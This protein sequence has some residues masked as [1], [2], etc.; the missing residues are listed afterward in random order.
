MQGHAGLLVL[1]LCVGVA[2]CCGSGHRC[3]HV[4]YG[5][6]APLGEQALAPAEPTDFSFDVRQAR[7]MATLDSV[8]LSQPPAEIRYRAI[9]TEECRLL[10]AEH[11]SVGNLLQAERTAVC[12]A[13]SSE[14]GHLSHSDKLHLLL[15]H[16][17]SLE[18]R[19]RSAAAALELYY[20]LVEAEANARIL[21]EALRLLDEAA[22]ELKRAREAELPVGTDPGQ[23]DRERLQLQSQRV[24]LE[25][26]ISELNTRLKQLIGLTGTGHNLRLWPESD[27]SVQVTLYEPE[28]EVA[29]GLAS[30]P[31]LVGLRALRD[32]LD[33]ETVGLAKRL[34]AGVNGLLGT[35]GGALG[36]LGI[37][38]K[39][40]RTRADAAEVA[41]RRA[42]LQ[43]YTR[44]REQEVA[45]DIRQAIDNI[46]ARLREV[47]LAEEMRLAWQQRV[48]DL[49]RRRE[50][51]RATYADVV[52]AQLALL[53]AQSAEISAITAWLIA[54][55]KLREAQ[56][57]LVADLPRH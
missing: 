55:L 52:A 50:I 19:N 12:S 43:Q 17:S 14:K 24:E 15:L 25:R 33:A 21:D 29:R 35:S 49:Q 27:W 11:S 37:T 45:A 10:A 8:W 26:T 30:R 6:A 23:F 44:D 20:R 42:Q 39:L 38:N 9:T 1:A 16:Q 31:E 46:A 3:A 18:A 47:A 7:D 13:A 34:L 54:E 51:G 4:A 36:M 2:G 53:R 57:L 5:G 48:E 28:Q 32:N 22:S 56:G 40:R 41:A